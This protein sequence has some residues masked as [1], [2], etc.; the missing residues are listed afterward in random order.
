MDLKVIY[1]IKPYLNLILWSCFIKFT[2][3]QAETTYVSYQLNHL[4]NDSC[5][6][7]LLN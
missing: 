6:D 7:N 3:V 2:V 1:V 4:F 5:I